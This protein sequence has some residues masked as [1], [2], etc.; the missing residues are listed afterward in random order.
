VDDHSTF[1]DHTTDDETTT[2]AVPLGKPFALYS[3]R[4]IISANLKE[5]IF[6][7]LV[8]IPMAA[9]AAFFVWFV[10][11]VLL[12]DNHS[13]LLAFRWLYIGIEGASLLWRLGV[14]GYL[15]WRAL[16]MRAPFR[17]VYE[18]AVVL[19]LNKRK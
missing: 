6:S 16:R 17:L 8:A 4:K 19:K 15:A 11:D 13:Y 3:G 2:G 1:T 12:G 5:M 7:A 14:F 10:G 18:A 9:I